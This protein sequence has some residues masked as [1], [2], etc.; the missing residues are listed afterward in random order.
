MSV[1]MVGRTERL[2]EKQGRLYLYLYPRHASRYV[3]LHGEKRG[4]HHVGLHAALVGRRAGGEHLQQP[5]RAL[6]EGRMNEWRNES[7]RIVDC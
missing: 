7:I 3:H 2:D 4:L 1:I 6:C 5:G